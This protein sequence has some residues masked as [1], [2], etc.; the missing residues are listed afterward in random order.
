M[1]K[2][3]IPLMVPDIRQEDIQA[4]VDVLNSGMLVQGQKVEDLES[5]ISNYLGSKHAI[6]VSNGTASLHLALISLN[7]GP[8]DE[9]IIPAFSYIATANVVELVGAKPIFV[10]IEIESFNINTNLIKEK[11]TKNTKAIIPVHEFGLTCN[12]SEIIDIAKENG[13]FVIE[14]AACALGA[15]ENNKFAGTLGD[16]GSFSFHPRK[17]ITGGEGGVIVTNN[18]ELAKKLKIL[19]NHGIEIIDNKMEFVVAGYNYRMTDFQAAL[20]LSQFK[21]FSEILDKKEYLAKMYEQNLKSI[22]QITIP[23]VNKNKKH[24][25]QSYHIILNDKINRDLIIEDLKKIGIGSNYGA[26]CIPAQKFYQEKYNIE[27]LKHFPNALR[28]YKQGLALPLYERINNTEIIRVSTQLKKL[29]S[30]V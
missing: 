12:I 22:N 27:C 3:S 11:I 1:L 4:V 26:Q 14:D 25:W 23:A 15:T 5:S 2:N 6:V 21:R 16:I 20:I 10:D 8:G 30:Y 18:D 13:L 28:A 17:A 24:T 9:V 7:I 29:L 19:R